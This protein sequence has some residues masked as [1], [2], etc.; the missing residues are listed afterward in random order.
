MRMIS[1]TR[2]A[3]P[4]ISGRQDGA[5]AT[6]AASVPAMPKPRARRIRSCSAAGIAM[7]ASVSTRSRRSGKV[8]ARRGASPAITGSEALPPQMSRII[9]VAISAPVSVKAGSTPRSKR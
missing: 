4:P 7:P 9:R 6:I 2:S 1:S 8:A 5:S 3:S